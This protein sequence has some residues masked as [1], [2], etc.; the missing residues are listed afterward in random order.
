M[1]QHGGTYMQMQFLRQTRSRKGRHG[2]GSA[3]QAAM[4]APL[5]PGSGARQEAHLCA[6]HEQ[7]VHSQ[8]DDLEASLQL[9]E[10]ENK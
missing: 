8:E 4:Q 3:E 7:A 9:H 2:G 5:S 1:Q 10:E 6:L